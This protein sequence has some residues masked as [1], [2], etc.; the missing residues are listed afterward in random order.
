MNQITH[1]LTSS[2][3]GAQTFWLELK[4]DDTA[5]EYAQLRAWLAIGCDEVGDYDALS[6][7]MKT[8]WNFALRQAL[9]VEAVRI[10]Y[11]AEEVRWLIKQDA[12][13]ELFPFAEY[14]LPFDEPADVKVVLN[15]CDDTAMVFKLT[16]AEGN[17]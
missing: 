17:A 1:D 11:K 13:F 12:N 5:W 9:Q 3:P 6:S 10:A 7:Y 2:V 16:F 4:G 8:K 14:W 15:G